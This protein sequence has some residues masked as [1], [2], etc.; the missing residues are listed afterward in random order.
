MAKY[1]FI[2]NSFEPHNKEYGN[3]PDGYLLKD[4]LK[5]LPLVN[6]H[7]QLNFKDVFDKD[8]NVIIDI[9]DNYRLKEND[10]L[11]VVNGVKGLTATFFVKLFVTLAVSYALNR[12]LAE[13]PSIPKINTKA[14]EKGETE[15]SI[16]TSQ[17]QAKKGE[18]I[19]EC[20]GTYVRYPD[21]I[22]PTYYRF[23]DNKQFLYMLLCLG[24]GQHTVEQI[25]IEDTDVGDFTAG[26]FFNRVYKTEA[27][28]SGDNKIQ[29]DWANN[30]PIGTYVPT[31]INETA[32]YE[33]VPYLGSGS[34]T[35]V[36]LEPNGND[37][38]MSKFSIACTMPPFDGLDKYG[39]AYDDQYL[40]FYFDF[41]KDGVF[42]E[43]KSLS[44]YYKSLNYNQTVYPSLQFEYENGKY[45]E[46]RIQFRSVGRKNRG[47]QNALTATFRSLTY[48]ELNLNPDNNFRDIVITAKEIEDFKLSS[49]STNF[50]QEFRLNPT[51]T[52]A[53]KIEV[54][55]VMYNGLYYQNDNGSLGNRSISFKTTIIDEFENTT[56]FTETITDNTRSQIQKTY[57]YDVTPSSYMVKVERITA[58][59]TDTK[60]QDEIYVRNIKAYLLNE[61][62]ET[63][64]TKY[65]RYGDVTLM[66]VKLKAT[67]GISGKG[68]FKVK[69][70]ARRDNISTTKDV[71]EY[72][73]TSN[74]GG[75]QPIEKISLPTE[76]ENEDY[77]DFIGKRTTVL[78][79]LQSVA[80]NARYNLFSSF[81][82]L[83][84]K[85]DVEQPLRHFMFNETNII[86]NSLKVFMS[87]TDESDYDGIRVQYKDFET[88]EDAFYTYPEDSNFPQNIEL[89]GVTDD[90][91]AEEQARF[92]YR[93][94]IYR[95]VRYEFDT[96]LDGFVPSL[97]ERGAISH[98][99]ISKSKS[100]FLRGFNLSTGVVIINELPLENLTEPKIFFRGRDG[101]PSV[102]YDVLDITQRTLTL[103]IS[104]NPLPIDLYVGDDEQRT[105]YTLGEFDLVDD[106][107]ITEIRPKKDN[108]VGIKAWNYN[109]LL[110]VDE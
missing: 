18:P 47:P 68:Q 78:Q 75:R 73:W 14:S 81:D 98:P 2:E 40:Y 74:N 24:Q 80:T 101:K 55:I 45:D 1:I 63:Y 110:Y 31:T 20:F 36:D 71:L 41:Y 56:T 6:P 95:N 44:R 4:F 9:N 39:G 70:R 69:V 25:Y 108:I 53:D 12:L 85:K 84:A 15:Y 50:M 72:I 26:T 37:T 21:I 88:F 8:G 60:V 79:G 96:E 66:A 11:M 52:T 51:G 29:T 34:Y 33:E 54:D 23:E 82:V 17:N 7:I 48:Q 90:V 91:L 89:Q 76:M 99:V 97:Y 103:D 102:I 13:K 32:P 92:I 62:N 27:E 107:I 58:E 86:R 16:S 100:G 65:L 30:V 38:N 43:S 109:P 83:T 3:I 104:V 93:E 22:A 87:A 57:T 28:H 105:I 77:N 35:I 61:D 64:N 106:I 42:I 94:K 46:A 19:P 67:Q 5:T 49:K 10:V 59:T